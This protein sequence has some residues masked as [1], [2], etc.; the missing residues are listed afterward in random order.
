MQ[1]EQLRTTFQQQ[2][3][4]KYLYIG[5]NDWRDKLDE[6]IVRYLEKHELYVEVTYIMPGLYII[7]GGYAVK[8]K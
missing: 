5:N 4:E 1:I 7:G 3:K 2:M 6:F 8:V